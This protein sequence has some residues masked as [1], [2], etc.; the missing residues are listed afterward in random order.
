MCGERSISAVSGAD[1]IAGHDPEVI[2]S[3]GSQSGYDRINVLVIV[4][5]LGLVRRSGSVAG[6]SA[7]LKV[8][9]GA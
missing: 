1:G 7:I 5:S 4:S 8:H 6:G 3:S 9:G 2:R